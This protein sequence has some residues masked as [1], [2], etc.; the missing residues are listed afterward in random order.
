MRGQHYPSAAEICERDM[1]DSGIKQKQLAARKTKKCKELNE[2]FLRDIKPGRLLN[3]LVNK[4]DRMT[5]NAE[6]QKEVQE[7]YRA[8]LQNP[9]DKQLLRALEELGKNIEDEQSPR[10]STPAGPSEQGADS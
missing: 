3:A 7:K 8:Y 2:A 1:P 6:L 4:G 5:L 9:E 10:P